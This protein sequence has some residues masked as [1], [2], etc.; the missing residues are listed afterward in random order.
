MTEE[1]NPHPLNTAAWWVFDRIAGKR[2]YIASQRADIERA[3]RNIREA[4]G[5]I[6]GLERDAAC[7]EA[8]RAALGETK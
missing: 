3:E 5:V 1:K 8:G 7:L 2:A 6:E 4:E